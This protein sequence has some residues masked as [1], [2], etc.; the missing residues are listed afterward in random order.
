MFLTGCGSPAVVPAEFRG[1]ARE[2]RKQS[3]ARYDEHRSVL[4]GGDRN[5]A[6]DHRTLQV[7]T[8]SAG[9]K[10]AHGRAEARRARLGERQDHEIADDRVGSRLL[11]RLVREPAM[12]FVEREDRERDLIVVGEGS[13]PVPDG[14]VGRRGGIGEKGCWCR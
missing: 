5:H 11:R 13:Q 4:D 7:A 9:T 6:V 14:P 12:E 1:E 8:P 2:S 3:V 10:V